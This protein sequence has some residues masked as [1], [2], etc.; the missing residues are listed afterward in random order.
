M[1]AL[2][3]ILSTELLPKMPA[4]TASGLVPVSDGAGGVTW[5][6]VGAAQQGDPELA[7]L[8][9][10]TSAAD[11]LP[12]F[13]GAGTA[14]V[15]SFTAFMRTLLDDPDIGTA[16]ATLGAPAAAQNASYTLTTADAPVNP[17]D[18]TTNAVTVTLPAAPTDGQR[19]AIFDK[20][21]QAATRNITIGRNGKTINGAAANLTM[22]TNYGGFELRYVN[23][24][25]GWVAV[26]L[27]P[28]GNIAALASL[29]SAADTMP[30]FTGAGA[31]A[32]ATLSSF[33]RTF[34]D[35]ANA[36][37][38]RATLGNPF[39]RFY[40]PMGG[41]AGSVTTSTSKS[42][43]FTPTGAGRCIALYNATG[44]ASSGGYWNFLWKL[45][46]VNQLL[47]GRYMN[48]TASHKVFPIG[49]QDLG[50]LSNASHTISVVS[51][52]AE[53]TGDGNDYYYCYILELL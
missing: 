37:A 27:D 10:L 20:S 39:V 44:L 38:V 14:A 49:M 28:K 5:T 22:A 48:E 1:P 26:P 7:A 30:Y 34:I 15:S 2:G 25:G 40:A 8:A 13:T 52:N 32:L 51:N 46:G 24:L 42:G 50:V 45:D 41:V 21:G 9:G 12:Y 16:V 31:A 11:K 53:L 47:L 19:F 4:G 18:T 35:D 3:G 23:T 29:A 36:A 33:A 6:T 17:I 43:S